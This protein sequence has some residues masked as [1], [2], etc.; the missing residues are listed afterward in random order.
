[1]PLETFDFGT[2]PLGVDSTDTII[3]RLNTITSIDVPSPIEVVALQLCTVDQVSLGGGPWGYYYV[4][5]NTTQPSSGTMTIDSF[6]SGASQGTFEDSFD[7][8]FDVRYGS[9]EGPIVMPNVDCHFSTTG[10]H[11]DINAPSWVPSSL[12][13]SGI[14][15]LLNGT[16]TSEDFWPTDSVIPHVT[17]GGEHDVHATPEPATICLLGLGGLMLKK[18]RAL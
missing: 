17:G 16:D 9:P 8:H 18:R 1:V 6:P 12:E 11:W 15:Y 4:T 10:A 2:G 3:Q 5:L 13:L 7:V 14:N